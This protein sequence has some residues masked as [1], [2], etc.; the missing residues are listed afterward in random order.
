[1]GG[2]CSALF[3]QVA[4]ERLEI[5]HVRAEDEGFAGEDGFGGILPPVERKDFPMMTASAWLVRWRVRRWC[6]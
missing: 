4:G 5:V 2:E 1:M 3:Q 6:L